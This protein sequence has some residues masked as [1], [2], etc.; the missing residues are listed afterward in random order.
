M[1]AE[2]AVEEQRFRVGVVEQVDEFVFE[3]AVV[4]V[5][6]DPAHLERRVHALEYSLPL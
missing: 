5:H 4:H 6:R 1:V 2:A 3:V